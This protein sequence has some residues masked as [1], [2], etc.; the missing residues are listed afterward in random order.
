MNSPGTQQN[1]YYSEVF[2]QEDRQGCGR[3][4]GVVIHEEL[5]Y[6]ITRGLRHTRIYIQCTNSFVHTE[7]VFRSA[8]QIAG[9]RRKA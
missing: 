5:D 3:K 8:L 6:F 9:K 4:T 2:T 1:V 7:N